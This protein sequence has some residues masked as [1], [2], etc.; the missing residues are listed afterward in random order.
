MSNK[1]MHLVVRVGGEGGGLSLYDSLSSVMPNYVLTI[2]DHTLLFIDEGDV[3]DGER[4]RA[5]SWRGALKLLDIYP[6]HMLYPL[7][8]HPAYRKRILGAAL[9]RLARENS[10]HAARRLEAWKALCQK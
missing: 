7:Q 2:V 5:K 8:V 3:T 9:R 6:W 10:T 1:Q 4:G